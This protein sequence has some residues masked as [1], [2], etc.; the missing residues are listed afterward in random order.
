MYHRNAVSGGWVRAAG[1]VLAGLC[2]ALG[3]G[4]SAAQQAYVDTATIA[5]VGNVTLNVAPSTSEAEWLD[6]GLEVFAPGIPIDESSH[7]KLGIFPEIRKAEAQYIPV[8]LRQALLA[9]N[10]WGVVRVLPDE[11]SSTELLVSGKIL[12]SNGNELAVQVSARDATGRTWLDKVYRDL[13]TE[14]DYPVTEDTDPFADLYRRIANDLLA[15]RQGLDTR[16]LQTIRQV[17]LIRY[18]ASLSEDAFGDYLQQDAQGVYTLLRLPADGDPMMARVERIRSQEHLFVDTVDEQYVTLYEEMAP[19]YG[20]WRQYG[21][22]QALYQRGAASRWRSPC[23]IARPRPS[24]APRRGPA[25]RRRTAAGRRRAAARPSAAGPSAG[26]DGRSRRAR[27]RAAVRAARRRGPARTRTRRRARRGRAPGGRCCRI[28][29]AAARC[30]R[31]RARPTLAG[32]GHAH[33]PPIT[34]PHQPK[35]ASGAM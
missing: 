14:R 3:A 8:L 18:A 7:S 4:Q 6:V 12:Q 35:R 29:R 10:A 2:L 31:A 9:S 17:A 11:Q 15:F 25:C 16:E 32:P 19:T 27:S 1:A 28:R 30:G 22:E 21:R 23:S 34:Y 13:A 26:R 33:R 24:R 20:L 5:P